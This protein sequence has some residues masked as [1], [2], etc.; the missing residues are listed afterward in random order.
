MPTKQHITLN[1]AV[2]KWHCW[3]VS[4]HV[5]LTFAFDDLPVLGDLR[6]DAEGG[7]RRLL[8]DNGRRR[9]RRQRRQHRLL[10]DGWRAGIRQLDLH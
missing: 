9:R 7:G 3:L 10:G 2:L 8:G 4:K 6:L 1:I 5:P